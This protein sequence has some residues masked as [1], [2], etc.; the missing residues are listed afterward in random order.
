LT[1]I[2][3]FRQQSTEFCGVKIWHPVG[4]AAG[5]DKDAEAVPGL[6]K[7][8]FSFVEVGSVTPQPQPGNPK[9][10]VFRSIL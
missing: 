10:R 2:L 4:L 9:P 6:A 3:F 7:I 1:K 8:G 5:F